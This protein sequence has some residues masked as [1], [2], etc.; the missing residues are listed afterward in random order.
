MAAAQDL[1]SSPGKILEEE[2]LKPLG[3]S[4]QQLARAIGKPETFVSEII[5][6]KRTITAD[7]AQML[8]EALGT[9]PGFWMRLQTTID[10]RTSS[11]SASTAYA[12]SHLRE[13]GA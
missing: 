7:T 10:L 9:T 2:F 8:A 3:M 5:S 4:Q 13:A 1:M 6:G 12:P 11:T